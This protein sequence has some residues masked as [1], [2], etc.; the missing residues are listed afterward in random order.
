MRI[1]YYSLTIVLSFFTLG[2]IHANSPAPLSVGGTL[3]TSASLAL[4]EVCSGT[5]SGTL[6]LTG[7]N[8]SIIRWEYSNSGGNPWSSIAHTGV[9]YT[10]SNLNQTT[11]FRAIVKNG[12][13]PEATS[14][15][16]EIRVFQA[17]SVGTV[18]GDNAV[19]FNNN[20][21]TLS[22]TSITGPVVSWQESFNSGTSWSENSTS[23]T[24][25]PYVN[26]TATVWYRVVA[27]NGACAKDTSNISKVVVNT[28]TAGGSV[29]ATNGL[30]LTNACNA[31]NQDTLT[32]TNHLG[33][34]LGWEKSNENG[35]PW[36][37]VFNSS[38]KEVFKNLTD[39]SYY[40]A[41]VNNPGCDTVYSAAGRV[42]IDPISQAGALSGNS[43]LCVGPNTSIVTLSNSNGSIQNWLSST[44]GIN[45]AVLPNRLSYWNIN[46]LPQ[47]KYYKAFTKSGACPND[48]SA[49]F[50]VNVNPTS[51]GGSV[52][53]SSNICYDVTAGNLTLN[54]NTGK[55]LRWQASSNGNNPWIDLV[56]TDSILAYNRL[57]A[58]S[59]FRAVVQNEGCN[60]V[61][62]N[63]AKL[64]IDPTSKSGNL[65]G[66]GPICIS[67]N[68]GKV[69]A[70]NK[71]GSTIDWL[72][73]TN[74]GA[75]WS[76]E[77]TNSDTIAYTNLINE[78][79]Y[80]SIVKSGVCITDTTAVGKLT[81]SPA[82]V[83]G[84]VSGSGKVCAS[85]NGATLKLTG[86]T[87]SIIRWESSYNSGGPWGSFPNSTDSLIYSNLLSSAYFRAIVQSTDCD[88]IPSSPAFIEVIPEI[89]GGNLNGTAAV[90]DASNS[91]LISL[92]NHRGTIDKWQISNDTM[93]TW[94]DIVNTSSK[95]NYNNLT[96]SSHYRVQISGGVCGSLFSDTAVV[97]VNSSP[98]ANFSAPTV[99]NK[100]IT[101][102]SN[103]TINGKANTYFWDFGDG[104]SALTSNPNHVFSSPGSYTVQLVATSANNCKA[105]NSKTV[106]VDT[107]PSVNFSNTTECFGHSTVFTNSSTP[108]SGASAWTFG[109]GSS[110]SAYSPS[111][112][113]SRNG[114]YKATL[115]FT[116]AN[117]CSD[118]MVKI[119]T[120]HATPES[121]WTAPTTAEGI[122]LTFANNSTIAAG[123]LGY[124][125]SFGD[126]NSSNAQNP[127]HTYADTGNFSVGLISYTQNCSDTLIKSVAVN[128]VPQA[129]FSVNRVC[130]IDSARFIN[131]SF[132][133]KDGMSYSW[134]FGD[135]GT[136]TD[137][138]PVH[139]YTAPGAYN[140]IMTSTSDSG[141]TDSKQLTLVIYESPAANFSSTSVCAGDTT[142]FTDN[143]FIKGGGLSYLWDFGVS[144]SRSITKNPKLAYTASGNTSAKLIVTSANGCVDSISKNVQVFALPVAKFGTDT[145]CAGASTRFTDS[146]AVSSA[147]IGSFSWDF[148]NNN[149]SNI[150][151]PLHQYTNY[152][153]YN[154]KLIVTSNQGCVDSLS[155][156]VL[157]NALPTAAYSVTDKCINDSSVFTNISTYPLA[158]GSLAYSWD[159]GDG[160]GSTSLVNP[161]YAYASDGTFSAK[162]VVTE[163][164]TSCKDSIS[165][166]VIA[167]PRSNTSFNAVNVCLGEAMTFQNTSIVKLGNLTSNWNF[168]DLSTSAVPQPTH[169]YVNAGTFIVKLITTTINNCTDTAIKDI[170]INPQP[171]TNFSLS[172]LC[173]KDSAFLFDNSQYSNGTNI[174]DTAVN[175]VWDLG[176]GNASTLKNPTHYYSGPGNFKI[177]LTQKTDSGCTDQQTKNITIYANPVADF[178]F[179]N[180]CFNDTTP[181]TNR[182]FGTQGVLSYKWDF[183]SG[184]TDTLENVDYLFPIEGEN[185]VTLVTTSEFGCT[186]TAIKKV[187]SYEAPTVNF[188]YAPICD[189]FK[190]P[191]ID[192]S[193]IAR[194]I[195]TSYTWDF[196]DGTGAN[197]ASPSHLYLNH[198]VYSVSLKAVSDKGC[199]SKDNKNVEVFEVPVANFSVGNACL[200]SGLKP[201]NTSSIKNGSLS[202]KWTLGTSFESILSEPL[203]I[204]ESARKYKIKL[205]TFS[206]N[207]CT[208]SIIRD[209]EINQLPD[210]QVGNDTTIGKGF[211]VQLLASG[212]VS[213]SWIPQK[214]LSSSAISSPIYNAIEDG[215]FTVTGVDE[216]GCTNTAMQIISVTDDYNLRPTNIITPDGNGQNDFWIIQNIE[217]YQKGIISIFDRW[218]G[219]VFNTI[220]YQ[221]DWDGR[222]KNGDI[223]PDGSYFYTISFPDNERTYKG[224]IS[225]MRNNK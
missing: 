11:Y 65:A 186:D 189:G 206:E 138:N 78:T 17:T 57:K 124:L 156:N 218:G 181:F 184:N 43:N 154:V 132:I 163:T 26:L 58:T 209:V 34:V 15:A 62:S 125:W 39:T 44:D 165:R 219:E 123:N 208:D 32:L 87:G 16:V 180:V 37:Y 178:I 201:N 24:T 172:N 25:R 149:G 141:Y 20:A 84:S 207:L 173:F 76:L 19:C 130:V 188:V 100:S 99:C 1:L 220:E 35:G 147:S 64:T 136:S 89:L 82:T 152:G 115:L 120:V 135:G 107:L 48:T 166:S 101:T 74:N 73:S 168:G 196:G 27:K 7:R 158:G 33:N 211:N 55:V 217:N 9:S 148:G 204:P 8:G 175:F 103:Q 164:N 56:K 45:Y 51:V 29:L 150:K 111:K 193:K 91:G 13:D 110:S 28:Q 67:G 71:V 47:T 210:I 38:A 205:I 70:Q 63:A 49:A 10:Y 151:N 128:P 69:F 213:Y 192:S 174:P 18:T 54:G 12:G 21:G 50:K 80:K 182:S 176:D 85:S 6:T 221:N 167:H 171:A 214:G 191:F 215:V 75:T 142:L 157:V 112:A 68:T 140:I 61:F 159:F 225:I 81:I 222:N 4:E 94:N 190:M 60:I 42:D 97:L 77:G 145:V 216:N 153:T 195:I 98:I 79:W 131:S 212:G 146:S 137:Q 155:K 119:V 116:A 117:N 194:G 46:N 198:G 144:G 83:G 114:T 86:Y 104:N 108:A 96:I 93:K 109:N 92:V 183:G 129:N 22:Y 23:N 127:T 134:I 66:I 126:G 185:K 90:C 139:K 2:T 170:W 118:S 179:N 133:K 14:S 53:G 40:R 5:N 161:K 197:I 72:S 106:V 143:S 52:S 36:S 177:T 200:N 113:Y 203:F 105:T 102:F 95:L 169:T 187:L 160:I 224:A 162:L 223:L 121:I 3:F 202:Y 59:S 41:I 31:D 30:S 199:L 122:A 88:A